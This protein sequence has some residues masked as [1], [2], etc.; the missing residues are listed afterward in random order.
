MILKASDNVAPSPFVGR[1]FDASPDGK[2]L[3]VIKPVAEANEQQPQIVLVQHFDQELKP[4]VPAN[5]A[6]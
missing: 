5:S 2:Q 4:L 1:M 3:L 6:Q